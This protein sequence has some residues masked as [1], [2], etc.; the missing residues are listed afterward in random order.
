MAK[1]QGVSTFH[2]QYSDDF[3]PISRPASSV[4]F[5]EEIITYEDAS[6]SPSQSSSS[7]TT[8]FDS[9]NSRSKFS[10]VETVATEPK[11][12]ESYTYTDAFT[13]EIP[14]EKTERKLS[15]TISAQEDIS[16]EEEAS[17]VWSSET[18]SCTSITDTDHLDDSE[19]S[20][21]ADF[22]ESSTTRKSPGLSTTEYQTFSYV[23]SDDS[24]MT[25]QLNTQD[26]KQ[27]FIAK[28]MNNLQLNQLD[29]RRNMAPM[30]PNKVTL[31]KL[32]EIDALNSFCRSRV[33]QL[34]SDDR[35]L[36]TALSSRERLT[37][38]HS[39]DLASNYGITDHQINRILLKNTQAKLQKMAEDD[40]HDVRSCQ[41]C[42]KKVE[43]MAEVDFVKRAKAIV[44]EKLI[45]E[46]VEWNAI[47]SHDP[48]CLQ[49]EALRDLPYFGGCTSREIL[50]KWQDAILTEKQK[51]QT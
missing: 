10:Y 35:P 51:N 26:A 25:P 36:C 39:S 6:F 47:W 17:S 48:I 43:K 27:A 31:S 37:G 18:R 21:S 1:N 9:D 11:N 34:Q 20:Y 19:V 45:N 22:T 5:S 46:K 40:P 28:C 16:Y 44:S 15:E 3:E 24:R 33:E 30:L 50:D 12:N 7:Y 8:D 49:G 13:S 38:V 4:R 2:S 42:S 32:S 14:T 41:K 29:K 23:D